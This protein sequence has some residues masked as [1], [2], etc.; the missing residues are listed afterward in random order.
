[1][2]PKFFYVFASPAEKGTHSP[3]TVFHRVD[4][5]KI[6]TSLCSLF[7]RQFMGSTGLPSF[8]YKAAELLSEEDQILMEAAIDALAQYDDPDRLIYDPPPSQH[9]INLATWARRADK[10][11]DA[12]R[13]RGKPPNR[14]SDSPVA[15][16]SASARDAESPPE[17]PE[18]SPDDRKNSGLGVLL[19][20]AQAYYKLL[21]SV[22]SMASWIATLD[23]NLNQSYLWTVTTLT[24]LLKNHEDLKD[25]PEPF[26]PMF[27]DLYP[28]T[29]RDTEWDDEV[30]PHAEAFLS[31][32]QRYVIS[33]GL[34]EPEGGSPGWC[35]IELFRPGV[36]LSIERAST[37][38]KRMRLACQQMLK[39]GTTSS[40]A[41]PAARPAGGN[42]V[43]QSAGASSAHTA[44]GNGGR[45]PNDPAME[46]KAVFLSYSHTDEKILKQL[47]DHLKP[48]ESQ[49]RL[50]SWSDLQIR[51][52]SQWFTAIQEALSRTGVAVLLVTKDFLA[53]EFIDE[54]ELSP[55]LKAAA[56]GGV[57]ILWVLVR[58]CNWRATPLS[59]YQAAYPPRKPLAQMRADL[60]DTA[61]VT[62]CD[63]IVAAAGGG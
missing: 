56:E 43:P 46:R 28:S 31:A 1:M 34:H 22:V 37:Y 5:E 12:L 61:W 26:E 58:D 55:L 53:S 42:N 9:T 38:N 47:V 33:K 51:A 13:A 7:T 39:G 63:A 19:L 10:W 45:Q 54:H 20:V 30:A 60:R 8:E 36:N 40:V 57:T 62:I 16:Q 49:G 4:D 11:E 18:M 23:L 21:E 48:L 24:N 50:S 6:A 27:P 25:F 17:L 15:E 35:F 14:T 3:G 29:V 32:V 41:R 59:K 52:G 44:P 2:P